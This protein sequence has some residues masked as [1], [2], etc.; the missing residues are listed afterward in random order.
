MEDGPSKPDPAPVA[1]A[2]ER[3][4]VDRA[5]MIG[6]TPHDVRAARG[7]RA[8]PL[9]LLPPGTDGD[10]ADETR[11]ALVGAGAGRV[12]AGIEDL[13]ELLP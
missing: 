8:L 12:L 9:G 1:L 7:A 6:D 5:W 10:V 13:E 2:L 3:L 11:R 4:G